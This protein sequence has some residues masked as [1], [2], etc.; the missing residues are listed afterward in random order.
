MVELDTYNAYKAR[1]MVYNYFIA[2]R[3]SLMTIYTAWGLEGKVTATFVEQ[4]L[5]NRICCL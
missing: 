4:K 1:H 3:A 5:F 2:H